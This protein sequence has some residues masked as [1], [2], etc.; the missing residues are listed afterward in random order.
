MRDKATS[1]Y[2]AFERIFFGKTEDEDKHV[3]SVNGRIPYAFGWNRK[4]NEPSRQKFSSTDSEDAW[5]SNLK[6]Q[7]DL[8]EKYGWLDTE[9]YYDL[10]SHGYRDEEFKE[11]PNSIV[12]AGE[13]FTYATGLP[14]EMSWP[15]LLGKELDTK[16]WNL[17]LCTTGLDVTFRSLLSWLPV[18]KPKMVLLLENSQLGREV[19]YID[20]EKDEWNTQIGFWSDYDWQKELVES[21]TERFISR[22][23]NQLKFLRV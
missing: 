21:K 19:W 20:E 9:V 13:C 16:I 8:L 22:Q 1:R 14:I 6:N 23:K 18:I 5:E 3:E 4:L 15:Y 17:A 11:S 7:K 10:N 12:A 2:K